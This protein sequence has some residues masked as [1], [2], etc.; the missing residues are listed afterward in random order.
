MIRQHF[1][2]PLVIRFKI[3]L[4]QIPLVFPKPQMSQFVHTRNRMRQ[5]YGLLL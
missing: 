2:S 5:K 1:C 4:D 3:V